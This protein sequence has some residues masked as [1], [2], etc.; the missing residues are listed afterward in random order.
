MSAISYVLVSLLDRFG[1]KLVYLI[2]EKKPTKSPV[3]AL[4]WIVSLIVALVP[5]LNKIKKYLDG[6]N[7]QILT[8][9]NE[10]GINSINF[11]YS[12]FFFFIVL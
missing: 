10:S 5:T 3:S 11:N 8:S 12:S 6:T 2:K 1:E 7:H 4:P 9:Y